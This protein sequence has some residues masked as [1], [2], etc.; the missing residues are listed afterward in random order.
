MVS[1]QLF[2]ILDFFCILQTNLAMA[3]LSLKEMEKFLWEGRE[4]VLPSW[5]SQFSFD[6]Q[7]FF[8]TFSKKFSSNLHNKFIHKVWTK[9]L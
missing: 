9:L 2:I 1:D 7:T 4:K 6:G 3:T 8:P 5:L